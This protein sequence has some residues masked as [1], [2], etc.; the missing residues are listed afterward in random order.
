MQE[1]ILS[2]ISLKPNF[3]TLLAC[4]AL[5]ILGVVPAAIAR[6]Y[7]VATG[8]TTGYEY[9]ERRYDQ[10]ESEETGG[11][12][13]A[14]TS[15]QTKKED[16][17]YTRLR[18]TPLIA[19]ESVSA[20][21]QLS[22]TYAPSFRYD[23]ETYDHDVDHDLNAAFKQSIT[24]DW[25]IK[26]DERYL[27]TDA[28]ISQNAT[29]TE[30][31][32]EIS[33]TSGRRKYWT[34]DAGLATDY[35]YW[36]DCLLSLGYSFGKLENVDVETTNNYENYDRHVASLSVGHR[37]DSFWKLTTTGK[38]VRGLYDKPTEQDTTTD[39]TV[40]KDLREYRASTVLESRLIELH[41]LS[42]S[43]SY[44]G[45]DYDDPDQ[46]SNGLHDAT[47]GWQWDMAK[48]LQ[49]ALGAGP[50]YQKTEGEKGTWGYNANGH[51]KYAIERGAF[52]LSARRG[53]DRQNFTGTNENGL[54]K[55]W[56]A[57][58]DFNYEVVQD[59][60]LNMFTT[61]RWEDQE[62]ITSAKLDST[63]SSATA[64]NSEIIYQ[65]DTFNRQRFGAG[66]NLG[67]KFWQSYLLS[68]SYN[69]LLQD[70]E[71]TNDSYEEHRL[72]LSLSVKND[73]LNW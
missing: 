67:Y 32:V 38:Y 31:S 69:Y 50:S 42:L 33:D 61:Y 10:D 71:K 8:L 17:K 12:G 7:K 57:K 1:D 45:V 14:T 46:L 22:L 13:E 52:D 26:L 64:S 37:F 23:Y 56:D 30:N 40:N 65:T 73:L 59:L 24:R 49:I 4:L 44:L 18:L 11:D 43:Y 54:R 53:Y 58:V 70:S 19:V 48:T 55:F 21:D 66:T 16:D 39:T 6:D 51:V 34:N 29:Q 36:Q 28:N 41:P 47:L 68:L 9:Y 27:L 3:A 62:E 72:V 2:K 20:H 63:D 15:S 35:S 25:L 5:A 60:A